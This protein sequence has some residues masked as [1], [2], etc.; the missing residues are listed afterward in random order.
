MLTKPRPVDQLRQLLLNSNGPDAEE[1]SSFFKL[2]KEEQ[3]CATCLILACATGTAADSQ[4]RQCSNL[5][6]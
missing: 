3:A 4:V 1:V 5:P 2:H 6:V